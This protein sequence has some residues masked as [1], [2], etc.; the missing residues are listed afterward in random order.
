MG[1]VL[2]RLAAL[3]AVVALVA[4]LPAPCPCPEEGAAPPKGH[5]CCAPPTGVSADDHGCC[6]TPAEAADILVPPAGPAPTLVEATVHR[7]ETA[8]RVEASPCLPAVLAPSPPPAILR[9]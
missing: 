6:D 3:A 1:R 2:R 8:A 9:L 7:L 4:T 5:E